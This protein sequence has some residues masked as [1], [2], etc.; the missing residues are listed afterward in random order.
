MEIDYIKQISE[1]E[2]NIKKN[3]IP[4]IADLVK[5]TFVAWYMLVE[6]NLLLREDYL[7]EILNRN[8]NLIHTFY[9]GNPELQFLQGWMIEISPWFFDVEDEDIG[10]KY[11][12]LAYN[13][14]PDNTLYKWALRDEM[15]IPKV[16][17]AQMK[18]SL[19]IDYNKYYIDYTPIKEYFKDIVS[20]S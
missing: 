12:K 16:L 10:A 18:V 9:P 20:N 4:L 1:L 19:I 3:K 2:N 13:A 7:Q 5:E 6:G 8:I 14:Q 17:L 11:L 15:N